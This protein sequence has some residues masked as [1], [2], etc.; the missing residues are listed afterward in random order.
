ME[1]DKPLRLDKGL[2]DSQ[3]PET[4][5]RV[6][7]PDYASHEGKLRQMDQEIAA[8]RTALV[9]IQVRIDSQ[10]CSDKRSSKALIERLTS[11]KNQWHDERC[12][13]QSVLA[14]CDSDLAVLKEELRQL[15]SKIKTAT[16]QEL[17]YK[18][19][20]LRRR[21]EHT[22]MSLRDEKRI[23]AEIRELEM[24]RPALIAYIG[25]GQAVAAKETERSTI[26]E[27]IKALWANINSTKKQIDEEIVKTRK[28]ELLIQ[29]EIP[30]LKSQREDLHQRL[31]SLETQRK[32]LS[33][34]FDSQVKAY[35]NQAKILKFVQLI[36]KRLK[37]GR[38]GAN[39]EEGKADP[40]LHRKEQIDFAIAWFHRLLPRP[41]AIQTGRE[42]TTAGVVVEEGEE[43]L[44]GKRAKEGVERGRKKNR[45]KGRKQ[46]M[47]EVA[48][49]MEM[50]AFLAGLRVRVP[51]NASEIPATIIALRQHREALDSQALLAPSPYPHDSSTQPSSKVSPHDDENRSFAPRGKG[52][53][54]ARKQ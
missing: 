49:S 47:E 51:G 18:L 21:Q 31:N 52:R 34:A 26:R 36:E 4:R 25:K 28:S 45:K 17:D 8:T 14:T 32:S 24:S 9:Q 12:Q 42:D 11:Q 53:W 39:Q 1:P 38:N 15:R 54:S 37:T 16:E 6:Q 5:E 20:E 19:E 50:V 35:R 2:S 48:M 43:I 44:V 23:L 3:V 33:E 22:T 10:T 41:E 30:L 13:L 40:Y 46:E 7:R 29:S 27:Q